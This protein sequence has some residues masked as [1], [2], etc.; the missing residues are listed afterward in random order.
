MSEIKTGF[1]KVEKL[2]LLLP[3]FSVAGS[4]ELTGPLRDL[5]MSQVSPG[6]NMSQV[7]PGLIMSQV[8]PGLNMSQ[9]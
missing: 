3:K 4:L 9:V 2:D 1:F 5:N 6:L 8:S 7:S